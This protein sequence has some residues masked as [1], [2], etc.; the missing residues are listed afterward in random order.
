MNAAR[1]EDSGNQ[2]AID[3]FGIDLGELVAVVLGAGNWTPQPCAW[4]QGTE[5]GQFASHADHRGTP[6]L[7]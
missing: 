5:G 2:A 4:R 7:A 6:H 3:A 1:L